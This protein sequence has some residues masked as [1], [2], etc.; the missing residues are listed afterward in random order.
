M[1]KAPVAGHPGAARIDRWLFAVRLFKSRALASEAVSGGRV[2]VN[3]ER[4]KPAHELRPGD[5]LTLVRAAV[6][7]ECAVVGVPQR[8]GPAARAARC[9]EETAAS[10]ARRA[11]FATRMKLGAALAPRPRQRP[12]KRERR[13]LQRLRG[14]I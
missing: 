4:V 7:F 6:Q 1:S 3:G 5:R 13:L 11:E 2:H 10:A 14:R 12:D 9:Y 8:R